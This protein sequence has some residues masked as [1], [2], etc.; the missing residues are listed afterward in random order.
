MDGAKEKIRTAAERYPQFRWRAFRKRP[1]AEG[2]G[3]IVE[4]FGPEDVAA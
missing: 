2:G 4:S 1:R 3:W